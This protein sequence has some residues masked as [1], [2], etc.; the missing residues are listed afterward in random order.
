MTKEYNKVEPN[1]KEAVAEEVEST[2]I[3][4]KKVVKAVVKSQPKQYKKGLVE[5]LVVGLLGPDGI[6]SI[7]RRLNEDIVVPAV[8]NI[9][10]DSITNGI[11]MAVFGRDD[12]RRGGSAPRSYNGPS[13][14]Y[15]STS[16]GQRQSP[17]HT[18][19]SSYASPQPRMEARGNHVPEFVLTT[20]TDATNVL[21]GMSEMIMDFGVT[22]V[23]DY[24]D[25]IGR[26]TQYT[27]NQWGWTDLRFAKIRSVRGGYV[28]DFPPMEVVG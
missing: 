11:Q 12:A 15:W 28:I 26:D 4:E 10:V 25:L 21:D 8:K 9:I 14:Q 20:R 19:Y 3:A 5:R 23:A 7:G 22:T 16:G 13:S 18:N 6:R 24:Y 1:I 2:E 17:S 27:D